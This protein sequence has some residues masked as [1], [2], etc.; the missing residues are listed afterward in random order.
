MAGW[1]PLR[2]DMH[3]GYFTEECGT[4]VDSNFFFHKGDPPSDVS[5][6]L[7]GCSDYSGVLCCVCAE[8]LCSCEQRAS[9]TQLPTVPCKG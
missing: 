5:D 4:I 8:Y 7:F 3:V 6:L 2:Y 9:E 1:G